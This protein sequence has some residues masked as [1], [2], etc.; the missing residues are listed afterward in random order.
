M[1][2]YAGVDNKGLAGLELALDRTLTGPRGREDDR[3]GSVRAHARGGRTR[4]RG[5]TVRDVYLT[6][7]HT[8]QGQVEQVLNETRRALVGQVGERRRHGPAR[9]GGILAL[10]VAPGYDAN[11]FPKVAD[12]RQRNRAVTDTYE[13]GSTFKIV[14][15][16]ARARD[17]LV[18]PRH[19]VHAAV[20]RSRSPTGRST[21][22]SRVA[23]ETMSV[24]PDPLALV[25]RR[26]R[27]RSPRRSAGTRI[28]EWIRRFGFGEQTGIEYPG[29]DARASSCRRRS[30]SG[31]TIGNVPIGQGIAVTPLQM[32][33]A[34]S[35][36]ANKGVWVQPHLVDRGRGPEAACSPSGTGS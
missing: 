25:E 17:G 3:Q 16:S 8:I 26:R 29:R 34:Y 7:D 14:T 23:T 28:S 20:L 12:D 22:P 6:I 27:S 4:S 24:R 19:E 10:A 9:P 11:R 13:P 32:V 31:S 5:A 35:A 30:W 21:T 36:I 33:A 15:I 1:L 2:G 18:T